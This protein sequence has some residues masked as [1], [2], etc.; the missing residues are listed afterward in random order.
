M[1]FLLS[2]VLAQTTIAES[3]YSVD[4]AS[5][6][7]SIPIQTVKLD[8]DILS[9][10]LATGSVSATYY[11]VLDYN[12]KNAKIEAVLSSATDIS[13]NDIS[14]S[15]M[16]TLTNPGDDKSPYIIVP[17]DSI[18]FQQDSLTPTSLALV[19]EEEDVTLKQGTFK[20]GSAASTDAGVNIELADTRVSSISAKNGTAALTVVLVS[21]SVDKIVSLDDIKVK[22]VSITSPD[23]ELENGLLNFTRHDDQLSLA[24][25]VITYNGKEYKPCYT[26]DFQIT[27]TD[28]NVYYIAALNNTKNPQDC[29]GVVISVLMNIGQLK[30]DS[31][32]QGDSDFALSDVELNPDNPLKISN[33]AI[34]TNYKLDGVN[35]AGTSKVLSIKDGTEGTLTIEFNKVTFAAGK[36]ALECSTTDSLTLRSITKLDAICMNPTL[37]VGGFLIGALDDKMEVIVQPDIQDTQQITISGPTFEVS[38]ADTD[39]VIV[40]GKEGDYL[41]SAISGNN[42]VLLKAQSVNVYD[43]PNTQVQISKEDITTTIYNHEYVTGTQTTVATTTLVG[44]ES[45]TQSNIPAVALLAPLGAAIARRFKRNQ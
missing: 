14:G 36:Y 37:K 45:E 20:T 44:G 43:I 5:S 29:N 28:G 39:M 33:D 42:Y 19:P 10:T 3:Y 40:V 31:V 41:S 4:L 6:Q 12:N 21:S 7:F 32:K 26:S 27:D 9:G 11:F 38:P 1:F 30:M 23:I 35:V 15:L 22:S 13:V 17:W 24:A 8:G 2:L 16:I 18:D 25:T 34:T